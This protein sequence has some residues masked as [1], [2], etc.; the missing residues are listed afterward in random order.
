MSRV[1]L[2][3][4]VCFTVVP[5]CL[6]KVVEYFVHLFDVG[7]SPN[8]LDSQ[9]SPL[10]R[11]LHNVQLNV[12]FFCKKSG[13]RNLSIRS[14]WDNMR[15][16]KFLGKTNKQRFNPARSLFQIQMSPAIST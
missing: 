2:V 5:T 7:F 16:K 4:R 3:L 14:E 6:E 10:I 9:T 15:P 8:D 13:I 12:V 1:K 11:L